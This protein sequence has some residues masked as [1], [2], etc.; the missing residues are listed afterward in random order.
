MP[1]WKRATKRATKATLT[2]GLSESVRNYKRTK[3]V[4][5]QERY[6]RMSKA[7]KKAYNDQFFQ[8]QAIFHG[9]STPVPGLRQGS[10][11]VVRTTDIG[12]ALRRAGITGQAKQEAPLL[13][14]PWNEVS[15]IEVDDATEIQRKDRIEQHRYGFFGGMFNEMPVARL[16]ENKKKNLYLA[17]I[18][19][20]G[21]FLL[22]VPS[23]DAMTLKGKLLL[24]QSKRKTAAPS[25][26]ESRASS[27]P[28]EQLRKLGELRDAGVLT[29][30]EF[31]AK[32]A[33]LLKRI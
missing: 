17:I 14:I 3:G 22:E 23:A 30:E 26:A 28:A 20:K 16:K 13:S 24:T 31:S 11:C 5:E 27:D 6:E 19:D 8:Y 1:D 15:E 25:S 32:K 4:D 10:T 18:S 7:E 21:S 2:M 33:D 9:G 29:E 12:L